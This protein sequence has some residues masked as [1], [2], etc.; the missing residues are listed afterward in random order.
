MRPESQWEVKSLPF[1]NSMLLLRY[2]CIPIIDFCQHSRVSSEE[3]VFC[4]SLSSYSF[5][6]FSSLYSLVECLVIECGLNVG[7]V[8]LF[9]VRVL[10]RC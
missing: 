6:L 7:G 2:D 10:H 3:F 9:I 4:L 5:S 8:W 1:G